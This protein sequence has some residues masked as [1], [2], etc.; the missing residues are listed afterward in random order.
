MEIPKEVVIWRFGG[1][2]GN[3][4]SQNHYSANTGYNLYCSPN[5][6]YLT[7][8]KEPMGINIVWAKSGNDKKIH[9]VLP[10]KKER[11]ILTGEPVALGLGGGDA[12]LY[13]S[14]RPT[15]INLKW[16]TNPVFEWRICGADGKKGV[17]VTE[18]NFYALVNMS[19][20]P[21]PDFFIY[22]DRIPGQAD[23][24]WTTSPNWP[25]KILADAPKYKSAAIF[26]SGLF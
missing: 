1:K 5:K 23:I 24:G 8:G 18:G 22:L 7:Y 26:A 6:E 4:K 15:G 21:D 17:P 25:G 11:E 16:G 13:Y 3:V 12:F 9:L 2:T 14:S 20:K 19:V 10:D